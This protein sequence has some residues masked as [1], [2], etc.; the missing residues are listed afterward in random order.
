MNVTIRPGKAIG[1]VAAPPS[2]SM[3]HRLLIC[4]GLS[5]GTS[6]ISGLDYNEDIL[7]TV[8]CLRA[9]GAVCRVE[10]DTVTVTGADI[11]SAKPVET[12]C[13]RESGST[14]RFFIPLALLCGNEVSFTGTEKLL[15]RPLDI[16]EQL[17]A[18]KDFSFVRNGQELQVK[19][20]LNG[21]DFQVPGNISSQFIT[22]LL[23]ALPL[24][25]EDSCIRITT[26]LESR[27]Y[28]DLTLQALH[29]FGVDAGWQD[30]QTLRIPGR[31]CY[32]A[33]DM[34][35]EGDYS[36]A[37]FYGAMNALGSEVTV[38]GL[39]PESLQ[40]DKVYEVH[41]KSLCAGCPE[42]DLSD[43]PDLGPVLFAVAAAKN[44]AVF[45]GTRRLKIKESDRAAAMA[46]E[47]AAFGTQ[48]TVEEN[49]VTVTPIAFH[50]PDRVLQGHNDHRIVMALAVLLM[51]TGG[52]IEGAQA[53]RKSFPDF[54]EKIKQLGIEVQTHGTD[55]EK[56]YID[57]RPWP[58][59]RQLRKGPYK[60]GISCQ[61]DYQKRFHHCLC[62]GARDHCGGYNGNR[63][64]ADRGGGCCGVRAVSQGAADMAGG[65]SEVPEDRCCSD[66]CNRCLVLRGL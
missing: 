44:G 21:G 41:L 35:V 15:S 49:S 38:T 26:P 60:E 37:A 52:E 50:A 11:C 25:A 64:Q 36:G 18:E 28:I 58:H 6:R 22:G 65:K 43:C 19:G 42:I 1:T 23:F 31:Q 59:R 45:T 47:L 55:K 17:S 54:F 16:Y 12:L 33:K 24:A 48:V 9:L 10:G 14:L 4:A 30:S 66:R 51:R 34:A 63:P 29:S 20:L 39:L 13:C 53:V 8:D 5:Q 57:R 62:T 2:K 46:L 40:G 32:K 61:R 56:E 3:A 27:S 7:A